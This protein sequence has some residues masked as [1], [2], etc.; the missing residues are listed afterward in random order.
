[1]KS[2]KKEDGKWW[3]EDVPECDIVGP[4]KTKKE[5]DEDKAG[6]TRTE[7]NMDKRAFWTCERKRT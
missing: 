6:L 5:A 2:V 7:K 4:Y 1:M 3:I